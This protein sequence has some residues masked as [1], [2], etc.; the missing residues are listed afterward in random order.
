[1]IV[2]L[3]KAFLIAIL[4]SAPIGPVMILVTQKTLCF[5]KQA[6]RITSLGA[7]VVDSL[8]ITAGFYAI[9]L[10]KDFLAAHTDIILLIGGLVVLCVGLFTA[11]RKLPQSA[12][13]SDS[14]DGAAPLQLAL[15]ALFS[16]GALAFDLAMIALLDIDFVG[17]GIPVWCA[18]LVALAGTVSY[19]MVFTALVVKLRSRITE[20]TLG[21]VSRVAGLLLAAFGIV[22][23]V[24]GLML[25]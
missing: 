4:A 1:M 7:A 8:F 9:S 19:W 22:L 20:K 14:K 18:I 5:G 13:A 3:L 17:F 2:Q 6:G 12:L 15:C 25:I 23:A 24:R 16:P 10:V 11:F 21:K